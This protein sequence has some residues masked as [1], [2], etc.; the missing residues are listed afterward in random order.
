MTG[1][2]QHSHR[3]LVTP[4]EEARLVQLA[5]A[6]RV[7]VPRL[8]IETTLSSVGETPTQRRAA[9]AEL[10][11]LRRQLAGVANNL[12]QIARV[13]NADGRIAAGTAHALAD[14]RALAVR[15]DA[16]LEGLRAP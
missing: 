12:N 13:A 10:F 5:E 1:G 6:Q 7:T 14:V 15:I 2:R 8:L 9:M 3:V 4:E 11:A 16:T